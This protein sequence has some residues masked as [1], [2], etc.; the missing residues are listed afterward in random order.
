MQSPSFS[1][2]RN[3]YSSMEESVTDEF[4]GSFVITSTR[5]SFLCSLKFTSFTLMDGLDKSILPNGCLLSTIL[6]GHP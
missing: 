4:H 2:S 3:L 6:Y 1:T 5:T